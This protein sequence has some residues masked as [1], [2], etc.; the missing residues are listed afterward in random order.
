MFLSNCALSL[1]DI[2]FCLLP[3][4]E[5]QM[6]NVFTGMPTCLVK[7]LKSSSFNQNVAPLWPYRVD[8]SYSNNKESTDQTGILPNEHAWE[9]STTRNNRTEDG[10]EKRDNE[11]RREDVG[12]KRGNNR[13]RW[14]RKKDFDDKVYIVNCV[15]VLLSHCC[16]HLLLPFVAPAVKS[17]MS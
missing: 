14:E 15:C 3:N 12:E 10:E 8:A 16:N 9:F 6:N 11:R 7:N 13:E 17:Q 1:Y 5:M 4:Y 2:I